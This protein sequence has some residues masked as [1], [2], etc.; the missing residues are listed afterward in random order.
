MSEVMSELEK[1]YMDTI[2]EI[3][4]G[5]IVKGKIVAISGR[6]VIVDVGYKA[7]GVIPLDEFGQEELEIGKEIDVFVNDVEDEQGEIVLSYTK[8]RKAQG[9]NIL[10]QNYKEG[11]FVEGVVVRR[12]KGGFMVD[13]FG[14]EGFLPMSLSTF[15]NLPEEKFIGEKFLF[16]IIKITYSKQNF[17]LSRKGAIREEQERM[18]K[19][20]WEELEVGKIV[21]G[22]VKSIANFGAFVDLG[23][24]DGLL[25]IADMSWKKVS[26]PSEVVAVGDE[27]NVMVLSIDREK[28]KVS[29]GLK[30]TM[31]DPWE[32]IDKKYP[33]GKVVKGTVVNIQNYGI[34]VEL[35]KGIEGLVHISEIS[36]TRKYINLNRMFAIGDT[37]EVKVLGVE[38]QERKIALSIKQLEEDPWKNIENQI[39]IGDIVK[40]KV[41][42]FGENK[43]YIY[44]EV[45]NSFEGVIYNSDIS[46]TRRITRPQEFFKREHTYEFK[47]LGIDVQ[48]REILLGMKQLQENPWPKIM[49]EFP[50]GKIVEGEVVKVTNFGVF[51][52]LSDELEGLVFSDEIDSEKMKNIRIND[53][54]KVKIIKVDPDSAKIG[55]SA[56][57]DEEEDSSAT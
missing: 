23:G 21:K 40:G 35:E 2:R 20:L 50:V 6:D 32:D 9:W 48:N 22:R 3:A 5:S 25:Y 18:K 11:D 14:A 42:G 41:V 15:K 17:I 39:K 1:A 10:Q 28:G 57:I 51:V 16:E 34:F 30:Q 27:I 54:L 56:K 4:Q 38:P 31:S 47:V 46:W 26:H 7:E 52:K 43:A 44:I 29:L 36:W 33:V 37:V 8:A 24:I 12:V 13:V 19:K 45:E 49:E 55:L 53:K